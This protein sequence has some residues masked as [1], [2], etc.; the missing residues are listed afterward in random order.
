M[1]HDQHSLP[2]DC[3]IS[4]F[5]FLNEDDLISAA[6]VCKEWH[7]AGESPWLWR[8]MCLQRWGFCNLG[9]LLSASEKYTW[10]RYYLH[11]SKLELHM[12]S[13]RPGGN[14]TCKSLRGHKGK[15]V[16]FSYLVGNSS[17]LDMW[18]CSPVVCS[19]STDGTVKAWDI[20]KGDCLWSSSA[21]NP[22]SAMTTDPKQC[23]VVT[24]DVKGTIKS[25]QGQSGA[26][27]AS[28]SSSS[29][30]C[31]LLTFCK[32]GNSFLMVGAAGGSLLVLSSPLLLEISRHVV[33]D[34]FRVNIILPSPDEKW[35]LAASKENSDLSPK[36][37]W[38]ASLCCPVPVEDTVCVGLPVSGCVAAVF[39]PAQPA[40][41][42][43]IH[44][45]DPLHHLTLSVFDVGVKKSKY[46]MEAEAQQVESFPLELKQRRSDI[47][48][49]AK[50]SSTIL[51]TDGTDLNIYTLKGALIASFKDHIQPIVSIC[52]DSF[53][54]VTASRDLSLRVL[55]WKKDPDKRLTL[56]SQ[57]QL[58]GGSHTASRGFTGV[59]CDYASIVASVESVEGKDVL[60]A[61]IFNS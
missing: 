12:A 43:V 48:L 58:L 9:Q 11:R 41:V 51:I 27:L 13:G 61:Y 2:L 4:I 59:A 14:Y 8:A 40:R 1:E 38:S 54:V 31:T 53:R 36:V 19:A 6:C 15:V 55:T 3:W 20:H 34:S 32:D 18:T 24:S 30:H 39:L 17:V 23:V 56:E 35:V 46:K 33:C 44:D 57:Y 22:V 25:W 21:G 7:E 50:G 5:S 29:S 16:G 28:F 26:E 45:R 42:A 37:F 60:K 52:V 49:Q 10:K 47:I